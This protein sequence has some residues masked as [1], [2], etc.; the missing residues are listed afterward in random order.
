MPTYEP[1][2]TATPSGTTLVTFSSIPSTY[3]DLRIVA[4]VIGA[5]AGNDIFMYFNGDTTGL[6]DQMFLTRNGSSP[7]PGNY[8][9]SQYYWSAPFTYTSTTMPILLMADIFDY[10]NTNKFK[11]LLVTH[12]NDLYATFAYGIWKNTTT[13]NSIVV[14]CGVNF[15]AG[16]RVTLYGIKAA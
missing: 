1:I 8:S 6:Y 5:S 9:N 7:Y 12:A 4:N 13:I 3:T 15:A 16:T 11:S 10:T 14:R 2:A